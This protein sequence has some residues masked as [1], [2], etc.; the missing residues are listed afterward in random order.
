MRDREQAKR[1]KSGEDFEAK[2]ALQDQKIKD[3]KRLIEADSPD[4][5]GVLQ[6]LKKPKP[7]VAPEAKQNVKQIK[8]VKDS[9]ESKTKGMSTKDK[10]NIGLAIGKAALQAR[11]ASLAA[12]ERREAENRRMMT[13]ARMAAAGQLG[14]TGR[15]LMAGGAGFEMGGSVKPGKKEMLKEATKP[16]F[17]K[18]GKLSFKEI[19]KKRKM[20][21]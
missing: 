18:G 20:R 11:A 4:K 21:Y 7:V 12:K 2:K 16:G 15:Q 9:V 13:Q 19:L 17:K 3:R 1:E 10:V 14:A 5:V 6:R 8:D